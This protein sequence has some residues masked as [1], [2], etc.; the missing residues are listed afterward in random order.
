VPGVSGLPNLHPA[1][2][3]LPL[4][5]LP[6]AI[7]FDVGALVCPTW[8]WLERG[9]ALLLILAALG[10]GASVLAGEQ[11]EEGIGPQSREVG[12]LLHQHEEIGKKALLAASALAVARLLLSI[13]DRDRPRLSALFLRLLLLFAAGGTF[14]LMARTADLGGVLVYRHGVAVER[15][16]SLQGPF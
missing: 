1:M 15:P 9:G 6:A 4:A 10:A 14:F 3:H 13:R 8:T 7:L 2:V 16:A 11:A 5:L 12:D